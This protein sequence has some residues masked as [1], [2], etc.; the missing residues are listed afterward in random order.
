MISSFKNDF[1]INLISLISDDAEAC[2]PMF[3]RYVSIILILT[4]ITSIIYSTKTLLFL[5]MFI[6]FTELHP[7]L[8][9]AVQAKLPHSYVLCF[10]VQ[11]PRFNHGKK[12]KKE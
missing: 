9:A 12:I 4:Y 10:F 1:V 6:N 7:I 3:V 5:L 8:I 2:P 11:A